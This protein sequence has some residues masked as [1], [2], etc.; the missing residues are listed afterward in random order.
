MAYGKLKVDR[1]ESSAEELT[2]PTS[3]GSAGQV[4]TSDG[5]GVLSFATHTA[6]TDLS[7]H[8]NG[9]SLTVQSSSGANVAL[10][11]ATSSA[12]GVMSDE[13]KAKLDLIEPNATGDLTDAEIRTAVGA[14]TDS[15]IFTDADHLKLNGIA[16][17]ATSYSISSDLLDEDDF[18]SN[19]AQKVASQ[20]SIKAYVDTEV[21]GLVSSAPGTLNTL[22]ELAA[23]LGDDSNYAATVTTSLGLKAPKASPAFTGAATFAGTVEIGT[24]GSPG[25]MKFYGPGEGGSAGRIRNAGCVLN[26][27]GNAT[28]A[29]SVTLPGSPTNQL[30]AATKQYVDGI[31][32]TSSAAATMVL[33]ERYLTDT[34][35]AAFT[36][37]LPAAAT[38]G[39]FVSF[40]D[41]KGTFSTNSLTI[42]RNGHNIA[43]LADDLVANVDRAVVTLIYS[44]DTTTGWLVK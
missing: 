19:S 18:A 13:D 38:A 42:G 33:N 14:A 9:T 43:G 20:Q 36:L 34:S 28:F 40:A 21:A 30:E 11:Q 15:N 25:W 1:I 44:G 8:A 22:D 27:N 12:W 31:W 16:A 26:E 39:D 41:P 2:L 23:A 17:G 10:P 6:N 5:A 35:G 32:N 24:S 37:A 29:G 3:A 7:V 4:L